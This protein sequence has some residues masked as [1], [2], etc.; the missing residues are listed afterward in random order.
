ML[1]DEGDKWIGTAVDDLPEPGP[2]VDPG[3]ISIP[4][5]PFSG[6]ERS[7]SD[8]RVFLIGALLGI[9]GIIVIIYLLRRDD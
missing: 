8:P 2:L 5:T 9:L 7:G 4:D 3:E 1:I 6:A